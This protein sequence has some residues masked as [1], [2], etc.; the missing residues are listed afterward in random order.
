MGDEDTALRAKLDRAKDKRNFTAIVLANSVIAGLEDATYI[1]KQRYEA[2]KQEYEACLAEWEAARGQRAE[3][4]AAEDTE[5]KTANLENVI[6]DIAGTEFKAQMEPCRSK[7]ALSHGAVAEEELNSAVEGVHLTVELSASNTNDP[8]KFLRD[9]ESLLGI[10]E[11]VEE[12]GTGF[13]ELFADEFK[14]FGLHLAKLLLPVLEGDRD[15]RTNQVSNRLPSLSVPENDKANQ[16]AF[17]KKAR[18]CKIVGRDEGIDV[19]INSQDRLVVDVDLAHETS[20]LVGTPDGAVGG[21]SD[22]TGGEM[23]G[24]PGV[25]LGAPGTSPK[26]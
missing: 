21:T 14:V 24:A 25:G 6:L 3:A 18:E 17:S 15:T 1:G 8:V 13:V 23:K 9:T 12:N 20:P 7:S 2:V 16:M 26:K 22:P 4:Y 10:S 11:S 19:L 5:S